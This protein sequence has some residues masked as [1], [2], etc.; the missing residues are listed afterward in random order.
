MKKLI[1]IAM[2]V[3]GSSALAKAY[4]DAGCG[5]GSI[6]FGDERGFTQVFAATLNGTGAQTFGI[7]TGTSNC[8]DN[9]AMRG[10]KAVPAFIEVNKLALAKDASRGEGETLA[11]LASLLGCKSQNLGPALKSN[12]NK[13][14]VET[15]MEPADIEAGINTTISSNKA[16]TCGA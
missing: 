16:E 8:Q 15:N 12:Y 9:G 4:G 5:L 3:V 6:V 2:M 13:I 7:T 11:G 1:V 14:F 10:A